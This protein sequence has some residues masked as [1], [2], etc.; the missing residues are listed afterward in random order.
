MPSSTYSL[1]DPRFDLERASN[2]LR[3][4]AQKLPE[5]TELVGNFNLRRE[6]VSTEARSKTVQFTIEGLGLLSTFSFPEPAG[7]GYRARTI[8]TSTEANILGQVLKSRAVTQ[9]EILADDN[10]TDIVLPE[11]SIVQFKPW[12]KETSRLDLPAVPLSFTPPAPVQKPVAAEFPATTDFL[13]L[14]AVLAAGL[15]VAAL[16]IIVLRPRKRQRAPALTS[17]FRNKKQYLQIPKIAA[18]GLYQQIVQRIALRAG[19]EESL[20]DTLKMHLPESEWEVIED[21]LE[22]LESTAFSQSR[23]KGVTYGE[24]REVLG[25]MEKRWLP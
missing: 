16:L 22:R 20:L 7:S 10:T 24:L 15:A 14:L 11:Y 12:K 17:L 4:K 2:P 23:G 9:V 1:A 25:L 3:V 13:A 8:S 19:G 5:G 6:T 21:R 18:Q